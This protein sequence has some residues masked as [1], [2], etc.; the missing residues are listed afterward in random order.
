MRREM[1]GGVQG[2]V[3]GS[4]AAVLLPKP[5]GEGTGTGRTS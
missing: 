4:D 1:A 3:G 5:G 2:A